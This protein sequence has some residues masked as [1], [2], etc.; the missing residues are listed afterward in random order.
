MIIAVPDSEID[1]VWPFVSVLLAPAVELD[2]GRHALDDVKRDLTERNRQLWAAILDGK[3]VAVL[4]TG[5]TQYP[6]RKVCQAQYCGGSRLDD[7]LPE[8]LET[9]ERWAG[10]IGCSAL[11]VV[12]RRGWV[13]KF[14]PYGFSHERVYIEREIPHERRRHTENHAE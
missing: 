5:I 1:F 3:C 4:V 8:I 13:R 14:A 6:G 2:T 10:Q 9:V 7:W 11:E 12:G